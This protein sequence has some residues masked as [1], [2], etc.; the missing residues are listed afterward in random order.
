LGV[1]VGVG[2]LMSKASDFTGSVPEPQLVLVAPPG[3]SAPVTV[4]AL[5]PVPVGV[6]VILNTAL[7]PAGRPISGLSSA[8]FLKV[9][10]EAAMT[11]VQPVPDVAPVID[12]IDAASSENADGIATLT[13]VIS[14]PPPLSPVFWT[15][16]VTATCVPLSTLVGE[17]LTVHAR[18]ARATPVVS[19]ISAIASGTARPATDRRDVGPTPRRRITFESSIRRPADRASTAVRPPGPCREA[20]RRAQSRCR[21]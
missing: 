2:P 17:A 3:L 1:G 16:S 4:H 6:T 10:D 14:A 11:F 8:A 5:D 9:T 12:T 21:G 7:S 15:V 13:H 19:A 20:A 18:D